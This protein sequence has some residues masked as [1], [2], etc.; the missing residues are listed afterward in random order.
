MDNHRS[1]FEP[2]PLQDACG[3][4]FMGDAVRRREIE[5]AGSRLAKLLCC[6]P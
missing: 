2:Y 6:F 3:C 1:H 5:S 4:Y